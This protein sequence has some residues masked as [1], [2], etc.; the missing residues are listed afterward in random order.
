MTESP[1]S[2]P[3]QPD[4]VPARRR[5]LHLGPIPITPITVLV[6]LALIG[7][8][9]FLVWVV[10]NRDVDQIPLLA[11]GFAVMGASLVVVAIL[12]LVAMWHAASRAS[13]GRAF[14]L[15]IFGG[16]AGLGAIGCFT[17]SALSAM[18]WNT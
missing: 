9:V 17:V 8:A 11:S 1:L 2:E 13:V 10:L 7:S 4:P 18:L 16:L 15:A 12:S 14:L 3:F 6:T 5:G